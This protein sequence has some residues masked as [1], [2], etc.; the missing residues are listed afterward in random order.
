[1][2]MSKQIWHNFPAFGEK[3]FSWFKVCFRGGIYFIFNFRIINDDLELFFL[4][5]LILAK[6]M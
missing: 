4:H 2:E 5:K 3:K 6:E 1:M